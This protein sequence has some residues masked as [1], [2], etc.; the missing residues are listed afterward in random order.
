M[1]PPLEDPTQLRSR[2]THA[3]ACMEFW[4]GSRAFNQLSDSPYHGRGVGCCKARGGFRTPHTPPHPRFRSR[5][6]HHRR[7]RLPR[8]RP[9]SMPSSSTAP[10]A[11]WTMTPLST[12]RATQTCRRGSMP[13]PR[14]GRTSP[15]IP[16]SAH[17]PPVRQTARSDDLPGAQRSEHGHTRD[18]RRCAEGW[19]RYHFGG[20]IELLGFPFG[21]EAQCATDGEVDGRSTLVQAARLDPSRGPTVWLLAQQ[22]DVEISFAVCGRF[23]AVGVQKQFRIQFHD[24]PISVRKSLEKKDLCLILG[25]WR[26]VVGATLN[27]RVKGSSPFG[28]IASDPTESHAAPTPTN[29]HELGGFVFLRPT[30]PRPDTHRHAQC[31]SR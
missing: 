7:L 1:S 30:G 16:G 28:G 21:E 18:R 26:A 12:Q 4:G 13:A 2:T 8:R 5:P 20:R 10:K 3:I 27:Q 11:T 25:Q 22:R 23:V 17:P 14:T 29:S 24:S 9:W 6:L 31:L 19:L 15:A